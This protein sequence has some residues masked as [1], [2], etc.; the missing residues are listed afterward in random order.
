MGNDSAVHILISQSFLEVG[1]PNLLANMNE[2]GMFQI[3]VLR[4]LVDYSELRVALI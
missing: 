1:N 4:Y 2:D 3:G